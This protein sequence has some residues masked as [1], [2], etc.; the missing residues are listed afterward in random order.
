MPSNEVLPDR[1]GSGVE[2]VLDEL[3]S[4]GDGLVLETRRDAC[5]RTARPPRSRCDARFALMLVKYG[6]G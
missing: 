5:R 2:A 3:L 4:D 6:R 1:G